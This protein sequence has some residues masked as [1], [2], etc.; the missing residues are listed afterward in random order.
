[1]SDAVVRGPI[2]LTPCSHQLI[3]E[4]RLEMLE[5]TNVGMAVDNHFGRNLVRVRLR[6]HIENRDDGEG[7]RLRDNVNGGPA[8]SVINTN[9]EYRFRSRVSHWEA[10]KLRSRRER[11]LARWRSGRL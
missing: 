7:L 1:M 8:L 5:R 10:N 11:R 3:D 6:N 9:S 2:E 4:F